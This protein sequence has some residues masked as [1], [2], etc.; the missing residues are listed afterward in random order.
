[1]SGSESST[2]NG[3]DSDTQNF[4]L[5]IEDADEVG[6]VGA[7]AAMASQDED[8]GEP[9]M[10]EPLADHA[11]L[12]NYNAER[13]AE[14]ERNDKLVRRLNG[15]EVLNEWCVCGNCHTEFLVNPKECQCCQEMDMCKLALNEFQVVE[16]LG[17]APQCITVH[18]GF[19]PV[20]LTRWAL[21]TLADQ[22][23][24][25]QNSRYRSLGSENK[26][27]RALAFRAFTGLVYGKLGARR[28]PLPACAYHAIRTKF[29]VQCNTATGYADD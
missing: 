6:D 15:T 28:V 22:F 24:T 19:N 1:M 20:C 5:D 29:V 13:L 23:K 26:F 12:A 9:Y 17:Q 7:A 11:W 18:P 16:E 25:R 8:Y 3:Y 4:I 27:L 10:G 2:E 21:Y 14:K